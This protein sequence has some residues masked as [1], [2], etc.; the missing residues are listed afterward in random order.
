M[1]YNDICNAPNHA[2]I[3]CFKNKVNGKCYIGQAIKIRSRLKG[4]WHAINSH[5]IDNM[6]IYKAIDKYGIENFELKIIYEIRNSLAWDTKKKLDELE[7]KYIQEYN[8]YENGYNQT[9]GGDAGVLGYKMTD[10]QKERI[11]QNSIQQQQRIRDKKAED[12]NNWIKCKNLITNEILVFKSAKE[13][14]DL[15]N[16]PMY[17]LKKGLRKIYH[18]IK[19]TW[20]F[21]YYNEDFDV[22]PKRIS[23]KRKILNTGQYRELKNKKEI[24]EYIKNNPNCSFKEIRQFFKLCRKTFYNYLQELNIA[25][26]NH[27]P[28]PKVSKEDF[29]EY[30]NSHTKH[31]CIEH[32]RITEDLFYRYRKRYVYGKDE[33]NEAIGKRNVSK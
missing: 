4:H 12:K 7:K 29:I 23:P 9:L 19:R 11:R 18:I 28:L 1:N 33:I 21:C 16:I 8:S 27:G 26:T 30:Y 32:F 2:G 13:A 3:Y 20:Q 14:S 22:I 6:I 24:C 10:E 31:E 17:S 5:S 15:L 25:R